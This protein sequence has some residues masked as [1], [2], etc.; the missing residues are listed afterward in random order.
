RGDPALRNQ[1][2]NGAA[3]LASVAAVPEAARPL[4]GFFKA[5][6]MGGQ[7][8]HDDVH[9]A[10]ILE[11]GRIDQLTSVGKCVQGRNGGGITA[12]VIKNIKLSHLQVD[13]RTEGVEQ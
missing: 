11:S 7:I 1:P 2:D 4:T 9:Q 5:R 3:R 10:E 6:I 12:P 13:L 8:L